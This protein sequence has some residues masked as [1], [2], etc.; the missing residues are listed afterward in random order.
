MIFPFI[1]IFCT[2]SYMKKTLLQTG[3]YLILYIQKVKPNQKK[4]NYSACLS[5]LPKKPPQGGF[6]FNKF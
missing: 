6:W 2:L 3:F 5:P 1:L 4:P